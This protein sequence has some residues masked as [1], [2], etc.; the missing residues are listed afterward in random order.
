M[1]KLFCVSIYLPP[2]YR[3]LGAFFAE[4][5]ISLSKASLNYKSYTPGLEKDKFD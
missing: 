2:I 5:K 4:Q 1:K 3:T